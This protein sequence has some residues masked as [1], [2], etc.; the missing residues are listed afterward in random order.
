MTNPPQH[1]KIVR[2]TNQGYRTDDKRFISRYAAKKVAKR[3][4]PND[5]WTVLPE[6]EANDMTSP[7]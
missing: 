1:Y 3:T 2:L 7:F 4:Y 5:E 6:G